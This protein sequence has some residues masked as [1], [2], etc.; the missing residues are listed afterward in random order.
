M[1][2]SSIY[3]NDTISKYPASIQ[4]AVAFIQNHDF[5]LMEDG[6]YPIEGRSIYAKVFCVTS[7]PVSETHPEVHK[8]YIDVQFWVTGKEQVGFAPLKSG[9]EIIDAQEDQDLYFLGDIGDEVILTAFPGD[10]MIFF[11]NDIHRPGI[12]VS[13]QLSSRK[14]VVKIH[15]DTLQD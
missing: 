7:K 11:P 8:E 13:G 6:E 14:V 1:I 3:A 2:L 10:Y 5:T 12:S 4:K 9:Y 15:V